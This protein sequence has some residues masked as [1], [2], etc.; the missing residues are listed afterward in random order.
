MKKR[1]RRQG[2]T[3]KTYLQESGIFA[4][5]RYLR[6]T[7]RSHREALTELSGEVPGMD[8]HAVLQSFEY[9]PWHSIPPVGSSRI[10]QIVT[11]KNKVIADGRRQVEKRKAELRRP[12]IPCPFPVTCAEEAEKLIDQENRKLFNEQLKRYF[13]AT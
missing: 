10:A 2:K 12:P 8:L 13:S 6:R 4:A 5:Y 1:G 7:G 9:T 3:R 11:R